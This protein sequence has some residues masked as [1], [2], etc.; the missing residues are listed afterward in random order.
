MHRGIT[1]VPCT[2]ER[3]EL[4]PGAGEGR[5]LP[6][7]RLGRPDGL[8]AK[9]VHRLRST[10]KVDV[11]YRQEGFTVP[12]HDALDTML[13]VDDSVALYSSGIYLNFLNSLCRTLIFSDCPSSASSI[14]CH[15]HATF[16]ARKL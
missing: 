1:G 10:T 4:G 6:S 3:R 9:G 14:Y 15:I 11:F 13:W 12:L 2:I 5:I 16:S 8:D 7:R